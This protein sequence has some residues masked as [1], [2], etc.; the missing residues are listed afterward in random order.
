MIGTVLAAG[1]QTLR[2]IGAALR[3]QRRIFWAMV[4]AVFVFSLAAPVAILSLTRKPL[5]SFSFNP[6]LPRLPAYLGSD[7][8]IGDKL[9]FLSGVALAWVSADTSWGVEWSFVFD[10]PTLARV[11]VTSLL[12]GAFFALW[13]WQRKQGAAGFRAARPAGVAGVITSLLGLTTGPCT[14]A[15][16]GAPVLP[17]ASL[18]FTGLSSGTL[19]L[20]SAVSQIGVAVVLFLIG[21]AVVWFGWSAGSSPSLRT[22]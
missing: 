14:L 7:A 1:A 15:G 20:V 17:V 13:S 22:S 8:P 4:A 16:C 12:F 3:G 10:V 18:A 9:S 11:T 19:A 2:G 21:A 6:W 5:D